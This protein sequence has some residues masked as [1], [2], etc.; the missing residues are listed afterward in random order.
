MG[1]WAAAGRGSRRVTAATT[2]AA[3]PLTNAAAAASGEGLRLDAVRPF[4]DAAARAAAFTLSALRATVRLDAS[5][6]ASAAA[7]AEG[8]TLRA[9]GLRG[10]PV[11]PPRADPA[12]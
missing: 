11:A 8:P 7:L 6:S 9:A 5:A 3:V 10:L 2:P 12:P 4:V 1:S